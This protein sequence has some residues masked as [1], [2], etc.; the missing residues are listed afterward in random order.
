MK[1]TPKSP[2]ENDIVEVIWEDSHAVDGWQLKEA[3]SYLNEDLSA[4]N[5]GYFIKDLPNSIV[6]ACGITDHSHGG[7]W[8]IPKITIKEIRIIKIKG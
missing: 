1:K 8:Q 5:V 2:K 6:L 4:K 7:L 3:E